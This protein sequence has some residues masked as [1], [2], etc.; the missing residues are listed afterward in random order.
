MHD[1]ALFVFLVYMIVMNVIG[2]LG[3]ELYPSWFARSRWTRWYSTSTHHN[4]HHRDFYG[5]YGLY[6]T[7]WDRLLRTQHPQYLQ[8]FDAVT[9]RDAGVTAPGSGGEAGEV[10]VTAPGA[11]ARRDPGVTV[12]RRDG[13]AGVRVGT[14][15]EIGRV[16]SAR[17]GECNVVEVEP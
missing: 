8:T 1:S 17:R 9:G 5:N 4:L 11:G 10:G 2:H 3:I 16:V 13:A 12:P 6:F 7:W 14:A 15:S